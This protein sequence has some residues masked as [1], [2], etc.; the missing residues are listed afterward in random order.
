M[1]RMMLSPIGMEI[2]ARGNDKS[3]VSKTRRK[4]STTRSIKELM[5][6][7]AISSR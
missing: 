2:K 4:T 1:I 3:A 6:I 7:P 5:K